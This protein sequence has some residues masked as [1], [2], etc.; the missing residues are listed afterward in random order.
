MATKRTTRR[1]SIRKATS[2]KVTQVKF[3]DKL[4]NSLDD[5]TG[6]LNE[7]KDMID[8]I[9]DISLELTAAIGTLHTLTIKY[10]LKANQILDLLLPII[11]NLPLIP[12]NI[13]KMLVDL[14]KYTQKIIDNEKETTKA[15]AD[16]HLGLQ[17]GD[18]SKI[19]GHSKD[20]KQVTKTL[21]S[22][23]K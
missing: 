3:S 6:M 10:A 8:T 13:T 2:K 4:T 20:L 14:E 11:K 17:T 23:L 18:V 9:Q 1:T 22:I 12:K 7:H 5:I 15:I 19:K 21:T 16:V